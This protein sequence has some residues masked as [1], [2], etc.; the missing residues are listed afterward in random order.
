MGVAEVGDVLRAE[1]S[2]NIRASH[3]QTKD[4]CCVEILAG[5]NVEARVEVD[6]IRLREV[7]PH[8]VAHHHR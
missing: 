8:N 2:H 7:A 4:S 1:K 6:E 5:V 3:H